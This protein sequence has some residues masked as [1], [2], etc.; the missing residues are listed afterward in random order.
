MG[1]DS[2]TCCLQT[3]DTWP[4][5]LLCGEEV[6]DPVLLSLPFCPWGAVRT[7][8]RRQVLA[9]AK[10]LLGGLHNLTNPWDVLVALPLLLGRSRH[11]LPPCGRLSPTAG[12]GVC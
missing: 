9:A 7:E 10:W 3:S 1:E 4:S 6:G 2:V 11:L 5:P 8:R 12:A